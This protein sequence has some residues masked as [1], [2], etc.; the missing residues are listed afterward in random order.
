MLHTTYYIDYLK[1]APV[2]Y[3]STVAKYIHYEN[4]KHMYAT[5]TARPSI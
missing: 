4:T 5:E 1:K 2:K 3:I